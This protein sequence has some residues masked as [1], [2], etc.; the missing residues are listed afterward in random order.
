MSD[1]ID[2]IREDMK[3]ERYAELWKRYG[4]FAIGGAIG[5]IAI[6]AAFVWFGSHKQSSTEEVA[7]HYYAISYDIAKKPKEEVLQQLQDMY[8]ED[9]GSFSALAGL[10]RA[11]LLKNNDRVSEAVSLY[12]EIAEDS[13][14][15]EEFQLLAEL[16]Y[17]SYKVDGDI[18]AVNEEDLEKRFERLTGDKSPWKFHAKEQQAIL[19]LKL[20]DKEKAATLYQ[21]I[22]SD[23]SAP[24]SIRERASNIA[25]SLSS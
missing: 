11:S 18:K 20:G 21:D 10:K 5:I 8:E 13:S 2:E 14:L 4:N 19:A 17:V 7:S 6:T 1:L 24:A 23:F 16:I 15:P 25:K 3:E 9:K 22:M 12:G